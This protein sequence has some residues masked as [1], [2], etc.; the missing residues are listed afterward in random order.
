MQH[1]QARVAMHYK[2]D[3]KVEKEIL[4]S[5]KFYEKMIQKTMNIPDDDITNPIKVGTLKLRKPRIRVDAQ[6][7]WDIT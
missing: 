1:S 4:K 5:K 2:G 6:I 7:E 3:N